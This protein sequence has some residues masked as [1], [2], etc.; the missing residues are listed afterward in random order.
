MVLR[1]LRGSLKGTSAIGK[2]RSR[3]SDGPY[4]GPS[5]NKGFVHYPWF[6]EHLKQQNTSHD[7]FRKFLA[8]PPSINIYD[9]NQQSNLTNAYGTF[10]GPNEKDN[11]KIDFI[12]E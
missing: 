7:S 12:A 10:D 3:L 8:C 9:A 4:E 1:N 11:L 5:P 2:I 6:I